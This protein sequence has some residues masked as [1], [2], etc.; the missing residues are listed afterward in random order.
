MKISG[1]TLATARLIDKCTIKELALLL[2]VS[3]RTIVNWEHEGVPKHRTLLVL[4]KYGHAIKTAQREL[5][6]S[7][8]YDLS[9]TGTAPGSA[10]ETLREFSTAALLEEVQRRIQASGIQ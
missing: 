3:E 1:H 9:G 2:G 8:S 10:A 5:A 6:E 7:D 4:H